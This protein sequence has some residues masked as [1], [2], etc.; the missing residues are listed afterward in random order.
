MTSVIIMGGA[1][2][3]VIFNIPFILKWGAVGA[4]GATLGSR[5]VTGGIVFKV[6]QHFYRVGWEY[7][8]LGMIF[9]IL[10]AAAFLLL[11]LRAWAVPYPLRVVV[12]IAVLGGYGY[13]GFKI[14]FFHAMSPFSKR[15]VL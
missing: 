1:V 4:A 15:K 2:V 8:K 14:G 11:I 13:V 12:K 6:A 10:F 9:A 3:N 5:V 7:R